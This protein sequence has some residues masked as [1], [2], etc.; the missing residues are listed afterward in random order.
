MNKIYLDACVIIYLVEKHPVFS[1]RIESKFTSTTVNE[2]CLSP[3]GQMECLVMPIRT[4]DKTLTKL[5]RSFFDSQTILS[6]PV[7]VFDLATKLRADFSNLKTPDALHLATA[8]FHQCDE[9][10]TNDDRLAN[11]APDLVKNILKP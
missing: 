6:M 10:W 1:A 5:F 11:I 7:P 3:L 4:K 2:H 9:F 8:R